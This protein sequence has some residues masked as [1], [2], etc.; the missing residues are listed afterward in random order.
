MK[1]VNEKKK[2]NR[3]SHEETLGSALKEN[4]DKISFALIKSN[5]FPNL[6]INYETY[7]ESECHYFWIFFKKCHDIEKKREKELKENI[8]NR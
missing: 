6:K 1:K 8:Y 2:L 3:Y 7:T 5:S 4:D